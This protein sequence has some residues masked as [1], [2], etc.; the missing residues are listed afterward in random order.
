MSNN[1]LQRNLHKS[2]AGVD[3]TKN[4]ILLIIQYL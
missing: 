4:E 3:K 2:K 1:S